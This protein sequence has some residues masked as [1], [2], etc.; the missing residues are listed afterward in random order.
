MSKISGLDIAVLT[1]SPTS[2]GIKEGENFIPEIKA[3]GLIYLL[4]L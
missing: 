1:L 2:H 3:F 4:F